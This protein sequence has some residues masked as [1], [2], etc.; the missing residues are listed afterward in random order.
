MYNVSCV[1]QLCQICP[2]VMFKL[3][4]IC[5]LRN[6][7]KFLFDRLLEN[8]QLNTNTEST[9]IQEQEADNTKE[10]EGRKE[11]TKMMSYD[12]EWNNELQAYTYM[13]P[14]ED[15]CYLISVQT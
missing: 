10:N 15:L 4:F 8:K 12:M 1:D 5:C 11:G 9:S 3:K 6:G 2:R 13:C 7:L 14:C